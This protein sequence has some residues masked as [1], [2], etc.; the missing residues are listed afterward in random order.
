MMLIMV[1]IGAKAQV[2]VLFGENGED[3]FKS[4]GDKVEATYDGGTIVV[5]QKT[6]DANSVTVYLIVIPN[7]G[8]TM[9]EK[10][11]IEAYATVPA[12]INPTRAPQVS[13]KLTLDCEDFK[14]EYSTRTYH[15]DI[16]PNL[17]LWVKNAKFQENGSKGG[18]TRAVLTEGVYYIANY[19]KGN[20]TNGYFYLVPS[21]DPHQTRKADAFFNDIYSDN[22]TATGDYPDGYVGDHEQPFLTTYKT[23]KDKATIPSGNFEN[24]WANN[25]VWVLKAV[26]NF[27]Y[28][29]HATSGKYIVYEYPYKKES[30]RKAVHLLTTP[31]PGENA[32]FD[33]TPNSNGY[34]I[35]VKDITGSSDHRF[36]SVTSGNSN[37]YYG[38]SGNLFENGMVGLYNG[39]T[40]GNTQWIF[41]DASSDYTIWPEVSTED[42][43]TFTITNYFGTI[44][45]G[46]TI[47]YRLGE[48]DLI[49]DSGNPTDENTKLYDGS[50][51]SFDGNE[52]VKAVAFANGRW[53]KIV[54]FSNK[55]CLKPSVVNNYPTENTFTITSA[56]PCTNETTCPVIYYTTDDTTPSSASSSSIENGGSVTLTDD[57]TIIKAI[58][59]MDDYADSDVFS[60][61]IP[62]CATPKIELDANG[63]IKITSGKDTE[64]NDITTSIRYKYGSN[65]FPARLEG[66]EYTD[67]FNLSIY[68]TVINAAAYTNGYL[69]SDVGTLT[70]QRYGAPVISYVD[71]N[72]IITSA[73]ADAT[74]YYRTGSGD[75]SLN[76]SHGTGS[77]VI[78]DVAIGTV[79]KARA[80]KKKYAY[81]NQSQYT[82]TANIDQC[83]KPT[84]SFSGG[85]LTITSATGGAAIHYTINDGEPT[86]SSSP[87]SDPLENLVV[88]T[89]V[90]AIATKDGMTKSEVATFTVFKL[91]S[92]W[93]DLDNVEGSYILSSSF[94][95]SDTYSGTFK[96]IIDGQYT[97]I[98]GNTFPLFDKL[99]GATIK[100]VILDNVEISSS[101]NVNGHS[102]A[103]ANEAK[104]TRIYN[105]GV[106][107]KSGASSISGTGSVGGIVGEASGATRVVNCF[108]YANI[109]GGI[110]RA[111]IV[112]KNTGD[113]G[114]GAD[115][116]R[117]AN[118]MMY[119]DISSGGTHISPVYGGNHVSNVKNF[120]EYNFYLYSELIPDPLDNSKTIK[121]DNKIPYTT[122]NGVSDYNDQLAIEK[123]DY[124]VRFPF[125]RHILNTHRELAA[126]F[127]FG[128]TANA[129]D[130]TKDQIDEI[131]HWVLEKGANAAK[132]PI[133]EKWEKN[134]K[135]ITGIDVSSLGT[136]TSAT[137]DY[138]GKVI[139]DM[140]S[141]GKLSVT[142]K[143]GSYSTTIDLPITDMDTLRYDFTYGKVVL[144]YVSEFGGWTRDYSKVCTGWKITKVGSET[145]FSAS[146]YNFADRDNKKKDIYSSNNRY[147]FA[148]GGNYIVPYD[149]S[150]ITIEA[151]FANAYYLSDAS[152]DIGYSAVYKEATALGGNTRREYHGR[153]VY[154]K[155]STLL[156]DLP[157][158]SYPHEQAIVLVGNYHY[159]QAVDNVMFN[160]G[161]AI[162]I[163]SVDD[164]CNQEPDYGWYSY[165]TTSRT[166]A[167]PIRFDFLPIIPMGMSSHVKG[168]TFFPGVSIWKVR[169]WF[170]LTET[171]VNIMH[172]CEIESSNFGNE[173]GKGN[174]RW[175]ANSGYFTQIVRSFSAACTKLSYIQIG[176]NA[177]VKELYPGNHSLK[178]FTNTAVPINVTG[179]EVEE[180]FMT[181][182]HVGGKL[183][184][185]NLYFW[186]AGGKIHKFLGAYMEKPVQASGQTGGVNMTAKIDHARIWQFYGG[187][188]TSAATITGNINVT[189]NNSLV[190]FYCGGPEFG[191][192]ESGKFVTTNATGTT[193]RK[194]YGAGFG[195]TSLTNVFIGE[196]AGD[197][198]NDLNT[199]DGNTEFPEPFTFYTT[200]RL[201]TDNAYGVGTAYKFEYI[202]SSTGEK[203]VPRWYV[204]RARFSLATTGSVIN[205]LTNCVVENDFYGAGCQGKVNGTVT[206]TLTGCTI[207]RSAFGGGYKAANN[208]VKVYPEA[209]PTYSKYNCEKG[210]FTGFG[211]VQPETWTWEQGSNTNETSGDGKLYTQKSITLADLGNVIGAIT[212]TIDGGY[213]GGTAQGATPEETTTTPTIPAGGSVYG[214][215]NES[216]S[217]SNTSVTL[218]GDAHIYGN[219][220]GGGN[221]APVSGSATV[222]IVNETT[223]SG[224]S[225]GN[226]GN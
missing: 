135:R 70:L 96:G 91:I 17:A 115:N 26:G 112:G 151:N 206:S 161:K 143:I 169:G 218:K 204:G 116:A 2:K 80:W 113:V 97:V 88:G 120:T 172:Q 158:S 180:C 3:K 197:G 212:L 74:I 201:Q 24:N 95:V 66:E 45:D 84:F 78:E 104:D 208:A 193:F 25:S 20:N 76:D 65:N 4:D 152:Y 142:V 41:D 58:A 15:V 59:V 209:Q 50:A 43:L 148:Q 196:H 195:G 194:Y 140:G 191:D 144:P 134:T 155:L 23:N 9:Q 61:T 108:S 156:A 68:Q 130:I 149:V 171:C 103:I 188:T 146:N 49:D 29:I 110:Y 213:V 60:Y 150:S 222:N 8:Y 56:T 46:Y 21:D 87:Y 214:G 48:G 30:R 223:Q 160:T 72:V 170:E 163:M 126:Y 114:T 157:S 162:T 67:P 22:S 99:D 131:G 75:V 221:K 182:Y 166:A 38:E 122:V 139:T 174:N 105:C 42:G 211:T 145:S 47:Y 37:Y 85:K 141:S 217:L 13:E 90:K 219:V 200:R 179:G 34:N 205:N 109:T 220:F 16:D 177:Y 138:S 216:K 121:K 63:K 86:E 185:D 199:N 11:T 117:I 14:D 176:G 202:L 107:A 215:G 102:G 54:T 62:K 192:M 35:R 225:R 189:I 184:G 226:G 89:I 27:Y 198:I 10:N 147:V 55:R 168:S 119:G 181:G 31:V 125:Y 127:L 40:D 111:G 82:V 53:S 5:T 1:S 164:D 12:N 77:I 183:E 18:G 187:G 69:I 92:S 210:L 207:K 81:S 52:I 57:M 28:M 173:D 178:T 73:D 106:L 132:Y 153:T 64:G 133:I 129:G 94:S 44:P 123:E 101:E 224:N 175:I 93:E 36:F 165:M 137:K 190:D 39:P 51:V 7:K 136:T 6:V 98:T 186:C 154:T 19:N 128:S 118:C 83:A 159:N 203:L 71:G 33:I 100:N 79:V 32:K 167:P 124:L